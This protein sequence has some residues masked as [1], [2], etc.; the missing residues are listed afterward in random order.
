MAVKDR[1]T[2]TTQIDGTIYDNNANLIEAATHNQLLKDLLDS[3][4]NTTSDAS[5]IFGTDTQ[6]SIPDSSTTNINMIAV[7]TNRFVKIVY[8]IEYSGSYEGGEILLINGSAADIDANRFGDVFG[9]VTFTTD[10]VGGYLR[11]KI[12]TTGIGGAMKFRYKIIPLTNSV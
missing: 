6:I 12:T 11:L 8:T 2:L 10:V 3:S 4:V 7:A 9:G 1:T 5:R